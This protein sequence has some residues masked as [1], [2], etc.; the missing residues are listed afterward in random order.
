MPWIRYAG[1]RH[2]LRHLPSLALQIRSIAL[3]LLASVHGHRF[4]TE[5]P[6]RP[7]AE[8]DAQHLS[9]MAWS[10]LIHL[11]GRHQILTVPKIVH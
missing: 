1:F 10:F 3:W 5:L 7:K 2:L 11:R 6:H 9:Q 8:T 4:Q